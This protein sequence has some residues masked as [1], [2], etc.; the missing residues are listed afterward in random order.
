MRIKQKLIFGFVIISLLVG[1]VGF[2]GLYANNHIVTS[3][4]KG[5]E[6]FGSIIEASNEVSSYAKRAQGHTMLYLTL[7]NRTDRKKASDR[8]ASLREQI[9]ILD[10][11]IEDP[12]ALKLLNDTKSKTNEMQYTIE[13][14]IELHDKRNG[15]KP[16]HLILENHET[17]IRYLDNVSSKIRQNGLELGALELTLEE[18]LNQNAEQ[19]AASYYKL[20]FIISVI[21]VISALFIG[22]FI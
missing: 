18:E 13:S 4:E 1:L 12:D 15:K 22:I 14:L 20:V 6:H 10:D 16:G 8:I 7:H 3:F 11:K 5:E 2:L 19:K 9:A 21:A 17:L